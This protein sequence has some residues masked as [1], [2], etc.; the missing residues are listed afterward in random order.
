MIEGW[1]SGVMIEQ[2]S[3]LERLSKIYQFLIVILILSYLIILGT[4]Y[5]AC[6]LCS[7]L[8]FTSL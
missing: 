3:S 7:E 4:L 5:L 2:F 8:Y 6:L 1:D